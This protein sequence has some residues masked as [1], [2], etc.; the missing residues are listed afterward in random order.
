MGI[1][2]LEAFFSDSID[3]SHDEEDVPAA[4]E[5]TTDDGPGF[6]GDLSAIPDHLP[7]SDF[8]EEDVQ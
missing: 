6:V 4:L 2:N 7:P 3:E 5:R 8:D 1:E